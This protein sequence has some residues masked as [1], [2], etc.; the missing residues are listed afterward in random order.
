MEVK[1]LIFGQKSF[2]CGPDKFILAVRFSF[3][4]NGK[5]SFYASVVLL[6]FVGC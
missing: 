6:F 5:R 4:I 3:S 1:N 2:V